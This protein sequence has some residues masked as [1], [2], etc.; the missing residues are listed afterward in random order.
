MTAK[1]RAIKTIRNLYPADNHEQGRE[2]L[3]QAICKG[4]EDLP[5]KILIEYACLCIDKERRL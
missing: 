2:L 3:L 4:W 1:E 5:E